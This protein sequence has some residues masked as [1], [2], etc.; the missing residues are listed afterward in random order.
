[1][2]ARSSRS[3]RALARIR[4]YCVYLALYVHCVYLALY[5]HIICT[6]NSYSM[7]VQPRGPASV[8]TV[9]R[10]RLCTYRLYV[11][12]RSPASVRTS[13]Y[14]CT[15]LWISYVRSVRTDL[16]VPPYSSRTVRVYVHRVRTSCTYDVQGRFCKSHIRQGRPL[17]RTYMYMISYDDDDAPGPGPRRKEGQTCRSLYTSEPFSAKLLGLHWL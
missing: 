16:P 5:V 11:H 13:R 7:Y 2:V 1:M 17:A 10:P 9:L 3:N 6:H 8:R 15:R 14:F 4:L 12:I